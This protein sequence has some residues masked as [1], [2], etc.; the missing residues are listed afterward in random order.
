M[1]ITTQNT[2]LKPKYKQTEVGMIPEDWEVK[3]LSLITQFANGKAHEQII[4]D[5]GDY[6]VVNSKFIS[7]EGRVVQPH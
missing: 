2:E 6:I 7:T 1:V 5:T 4:D 3:K